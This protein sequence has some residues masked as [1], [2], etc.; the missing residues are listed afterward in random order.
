MSYL[1]LIFNAFAILII[2]SNLTTAKTLIFCSE[3]AP[4]GFDPAL[5]S[6][7]TTFD[8]SSRTIYNRLVGFEKGTTNIRP[9]LAQSWNISD[10]GLTYIFNLRKG[11]KFHKTSYFTPTR[12]FNADDV[13]FSINRQFDQNHSFYNYIE[14]STWELFQGMSMPTL[15]KTIEKLDDYKVKIT[16][17]R[18]EASMLANLAMDFASVLSAEYASQIKAS[19]KKHDLNFNPIGTGPFQFVNYS[20]NSAIRYQAHP[21]YWKA[22]Q[23]I[24]NL[25]FSITRDATVRAQK[26]VAGECHISAYPTPSD[27]SYLKNKPNLK[28]LEQEGLNIGFMAYNTKVAPFDNPKVRK[29]LNMAIDKKSIID[30]V[31]QGSARIAINPIPPSVWGYNASIK[32]D[33]YNPTLAKQQLDNEG[34][35]NL[36]M[37]LWA[38]PVQRPYNPNARRMAQL[39][40]EDFRRIG[41]DVEIVTYEWGTYLSKSRSIDRDGALLLGWSGDNGDPDNFLSLLLGCDGVGGSNRAHWCHHEYDKLIKKAKSETDRNIRMELYHEAQKIFKEQA[42]W[43][44]IAHSLVTVPISKNVSGYKIDPLGGHW[45]EGL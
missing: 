17:N 25:V 20:L 19:N 12:D 1:K 4:E 42:P 33:E 43:A 27:I 35:Q 41:V 34:V 14:A 11:V 3:A 9:S 45:F 44:T 28:V 18:P 39:I 30:S 21:L 16:L 5:Y 38:M 15:I 31:F 26:L 6:S 2:L 13:I 29:A 32:D 36:S 7:A 37:K 40:Q 24:E 8:A 23:N 10:D 22:K